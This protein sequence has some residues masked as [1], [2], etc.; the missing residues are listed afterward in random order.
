MSTELEVI[1]LAE[2]EEHILP[3]HEITGIEDYL[4]SYGKILGKKAITALK[5]LHIPVFGVDPL[6]DLDLD[7]ELFPAQADVVCAGIKMFDKRG[8]GFLVGEMGT[9]KTIM[10]MATVHGHACRSRKKGG[11]NGK[12]RCIVL[13]P[14]HLVSKWC[15]E[16]RETIPDATVVRFGPQ[17]DTKVSVKRRKSKGE[18]NM[19]EDTKTRKAMRDTLAL[20][21][22]GQLRGTRKRWEK[23]EGP[24]Y[25]VLGRNQAKWMSDWEGIA[26][27]RKG[28]DGKLREHS[29]SSKPFPVKQEPV[30]DSRGR[31]QYDDKYNPMYKNVLGRVHV[32]PKCGSIAR[33]KR[34]CRWPRRI[35][36]Q[37]P[38]SR[39]RPAPPST[40]RWS[41]TR[42]SHTFL[43]A[44]SSRHPRQIPGQ[45]GAHEDQA[46]WPRV[47]SRR[48]RRAALQL[49]EQSVPMGSQCHH[50]AEAQEDVQVPAH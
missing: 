44:R 22:K 41:S 25:Y 48:V 47:D 29:L 49:D 19:I 38:R 17:G 9:G 26:D 34:E 3:I 50:A 40:S 5:P 37:P 15:R 6:P 33:D 16:I 13:C 7:R 27:P 35:S 28:P 46:R 4:R 8:S 31:Q 2:P 20:L 11:S 1:A 43:A 42:P 12:Y 32:C 24:E 39:P 14:D 21:S 23:P 18:R 45:E 30:L 10:G 36:R